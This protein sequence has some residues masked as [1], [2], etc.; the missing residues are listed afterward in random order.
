MLMS[1]TMD[2]RLIVKTAQIRLV[3]S[4]YQKNIIATHNKASFDYHIRQ[5]K[6]NSKD[7]L[8]CHIKKEH[9]GLR[10]YECHECDGLC[11]GKQG[12]RRHVESVH[13]GLKFDCDMC[14]LMIELNSGW[15]CM[16]CG[17]GSKNKTL[18][19]MHF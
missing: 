8:N 2:L 11:T 9:K 14:E 19:K 7:A 16:Q 18:L 1:N 13:T 5:H 17:K 10:R 6:N 3:R 15:R 12:V 4:I